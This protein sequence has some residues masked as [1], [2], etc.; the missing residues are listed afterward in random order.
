MK[1]Y[2]L[3]ASI[4][5]IACLADKSSDFD[6]LFE[7]SEVSDDIIPD[8]NFDEAVSSNEELV[9]PKKPKKKPVSKFLE[10][11]DTYLAKNFPSFVEFLL[12]NTKRYLKKF[13]FDVSIFTL[14]L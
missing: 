9:K 12:T 8:S 6:D 3:L 5:I 11:N 7:P 2:F 14:L 13:Y 4:F 10:D 1:V